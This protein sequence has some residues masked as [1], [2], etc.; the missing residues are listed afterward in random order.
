MFLI[1]TGRVRMNKQALE[2]ELKV[3]KYIVN[4]SKNIQNRIKEIE[5]LLNK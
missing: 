3:L 2:E 5:F 4:P 1:D